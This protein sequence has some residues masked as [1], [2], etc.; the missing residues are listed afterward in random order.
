[1]SSEG[2]K[3]FIARW[4]AANASERANSQP[5][6]CELCDML[7]LDSFTRREVDSSTSSP[8]I[9]L[10]FRSLPL[11][12]HPPQFRPPSAVVLRRTDYGGW[13]FAITAFLGFKR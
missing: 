5:F 7:G 2:A 6:L 12:V 1:M 4:A 10:P 11:G 3:A 9:S 13:V 8:P